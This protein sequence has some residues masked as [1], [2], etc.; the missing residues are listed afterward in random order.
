MDEQRSLMLNEI[1]NSNNI[2]IDLIKNY[3]TKIGNLYT[4]T[5]ATIGIFFV[6]TAFITN[7]YSTM[8]IQIEDIVLFIVILVIIFIVALL[9]LLITLKKCISGIKSRDVSITK[10]KDFIEECQTYD[11]EKLQEFLI[12]QI[13]D[14]FN[15]NIKTYNKMK[16]TYNQIINYLKKSIDAI[17]L[18]VILSLIFLYFGGL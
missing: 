12:V 14:Y 17:I 10:T 6:I 5:I 4:N 9:L 7:I 1:C 3:D 15:D 2:V 8:K 13:S 16:E 18:F 11:A